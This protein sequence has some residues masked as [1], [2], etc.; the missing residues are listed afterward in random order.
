[1][2]LIVIK[3]TRMGTILIYGSWYL[4]KENGKWFLELIHIKSII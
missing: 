2:F 4:Y 1:M 3:F